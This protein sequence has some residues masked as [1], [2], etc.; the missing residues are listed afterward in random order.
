MERIKAQTAQIFIHWS[1]SFLSSFNKKEK[2][3]ILRFFA[4]LYMYAY[5]HHLW[6]MFPMIFKRE[7]IPN[8]NKMLKIIREHQIAG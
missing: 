7:I 6:Y 4:I 1:R 3:E 2:K 5:L 8:L